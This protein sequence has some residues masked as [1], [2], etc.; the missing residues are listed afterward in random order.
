MIIGIIATFLHCQS[1]L[2]SPFNSCCC[3]IFSCSSS[4]T[5]MSNR[6]PTPIMWHSFVSL[7][8]IMSG[9]LRSGLWLAC[10][11]KSH[12]SL[13]FHFLALFLVCVFILLGSTIYTGE[14]H[15]IMLTLFFMSLFSEN[16]FMQTLTFPL[17]LSS[18][19]L[20]LASSK[21]LGSSLPLLS[22]KIVNV[23]NFP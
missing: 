15:S 14:K 20:F 5:W 4:F 12:R 9:L 13:E 1:H 16:G 22:S 7:L 8:A 17:S 18:L 21:S 6:H 3:S 23:M 19:F 10:T 2:I 11:E